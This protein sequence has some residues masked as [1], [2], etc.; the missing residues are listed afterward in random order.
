MTPISLLTNIT[1]ARMVSGRIAAVNLSRSTRPSSS[2]VEIGHLEALALQ[3][4]AGVQHRL[5]FGLDR[6][7]VLALGACRSLPHP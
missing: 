5:V 6:D 4:A 3:F 1:L 7:D 2:H